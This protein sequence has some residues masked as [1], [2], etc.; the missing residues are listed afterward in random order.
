MRPLGGGDINE[1]VEVRLVDG[2]MLVAKAGDGMQREADMLRAMAATGAHVP[3]V[4]AS[5]ADILLM[6]VAEGSGPTSETAWSD[7]SANLHKLHQPAEQA[8]GWPE[9]HSF[10]SVEIVNDRRSHWPT[11]WAEQRLLGH[12]RNIPANLPQRVE[13]VAAHMDELL[14]AAPPPALLH[15]DLWMGNVLIDA[16]GRTTLIDPACYYGDREVDLA[17]LT[18]FG[19]PPPSFFE[20]FD[21][22]PGWQGRLAVYR[23]WPLLVHVRLFG[24]PYVDRL[25]RELTGIGS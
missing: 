23:L 24:A 2:D 11:F 25:A 14:P 10:G 12:E 4:I 9:D 20:A 5:T 6:S 3:V 7:L 8:Y 16:G 21:L 15:G 19:S 17:M 1:V 13:A 22:D 18:L